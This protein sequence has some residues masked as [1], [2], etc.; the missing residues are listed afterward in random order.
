MQRENSKYS[1]GVFCDLFCSDRDAK[2]NLTEL[3]N[4]L[5]T[6][7]LESPDEIREIWLEDG[8]FQKGEPAISFRT[9]GRL[10]V[11]SEQQ[12]ALNPNMPMLAFLYV[13]R[14]Y[15]KLMPDEAWYSNKAFGVP[16]PSFF[17]FYHGEEDC[18]QESE[19]RLEDSYADKGRQ[20]GYLDLAVKVININA[21]KRHPTLTQCGTLG[22]YSAFTEEVRRS[23][24]DRE[25]IRKAT[26]K[27][28]REGI[29]SDYLVRKGAEVADT[30]T[31]G[32]DLKRGIHPHG[33]AAAENSRRDGTKEDLE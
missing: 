11:V 18:P 33:L 15:A 13:C 14:E 27:C 28:I 32:Y 20:N 31:A 8:L 25:S 5:F 24:M 3:Y 30:L 4:A 22:Q 9:D 10:V 2:K 17:V 19:L 1:G 29:L 16:E 6:R 23:G 7:K 26:E 12:G 21:D